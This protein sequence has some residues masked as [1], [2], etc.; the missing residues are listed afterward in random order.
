MARGPG[1]ARFAGIDFF[2]FQINLAVIHGHLGHPTEAG[3]A[4]Q[5]MFDLWPEAQRSMGEILD[6]WFPFGDLASV[7]ADGLRKAGGSSSRMN[8]ILDCSL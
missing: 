7:F 6:L 8:G 4:L 1:C 3:E 2:P 5:R